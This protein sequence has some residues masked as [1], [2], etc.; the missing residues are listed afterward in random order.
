MRPPKAVQQATLTPDLQ[1]MKAE[2]VAS[3]CTD[4][5]KVSE[6]NRSCPAA[7]R[8]VMKDEKGETVRLENGEAK[9]YN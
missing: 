6:F 5:E 3:G 2:I 7:L 8:L 1:A 9:V 4:H